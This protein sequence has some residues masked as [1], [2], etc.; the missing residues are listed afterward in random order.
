MRMKAPNIYQ[1]ADGGWYCLLSDDVPYKSEHGH[2]LG[3]VVYMAPDGRMRST[4][5][6][7]WEHRFSQMP[8]YDGDDESVMAMIRRT[9][10]GDT[11]LDY[12]R[13]FESWSESEMDVSGHMLE[14][15][16][17]ATMIKLAAAMNWRLDDRLDMKEGFGLT[18]M[19][20]D[21]Q[22]VAQNYEIERVPLPH[23]FTFIVRK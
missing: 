14:L 4:T 15:A 1:H 7:R 5:R 12:I 13:V 21:L 3:G 6:D 9:N 2:W 10:P 8:Y 20:E 22:Q 16:V 11:D 23:G 18:I 17:V 19:T